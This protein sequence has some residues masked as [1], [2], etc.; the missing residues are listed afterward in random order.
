MIT[1]KDF[2]DALLNPKMPMPRDLSDGKSNPAGRRFS[3][4]RNNVTVS[5]IDALQVAFPLIRKLIGAKSFNDLAPI[6]VRAHPPRSPLMMQYGVDFPAFIE[7]FQ[8]L[9]HI[10][11]LGDAARLDLALRASYHSADAPVLTAEALQ[12]MEMAELMDATLT[13]APSTRI[14]RSRWPLYDIWRYNQ[15]QDVPKPRPV[16]QDVLITRPEFDPQLH[17]LPMGAAL[18]LE[19]FTKGAKFSDAHARTITA[20]ADFDLSVA[21][22]QALTTAAFSEINS[23]ALK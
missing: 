12:Q 6:F 10:S 18:W 4:Y 13:L 19:S 1:Q 5:L 8:P 21:L 9:A 16:A 23:K 7:S 2:S 3:V 20:S 17:L 22:T 14:L 15:S 11:Y